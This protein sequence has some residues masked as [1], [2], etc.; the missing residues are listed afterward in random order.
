MSNTKRFNKKEMDLY[1]YED[2][3]NDKKSLNE[4]KKRAYDSNKTNRKVDR[5]NSKRYEEEF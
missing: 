5:K 1:D 2:F 4:L 3:C